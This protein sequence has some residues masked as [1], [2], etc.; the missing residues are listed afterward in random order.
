MPHRLQSTMPLGLF[1][2][3]IIDTYTE[4]SPLD[5]IMP[6]LY[7]AA[8]LAFGSQS[9]DK[10]NDFVFSILKTGLSK[11]AELYP[12]LTSEF[13]RDVSNHLILEQSI[14]PDEIA[15]V[16]KD[17]TQFGSEWIGSYQK[18][19]TSGMTGLDAKILAPIVAGIGTT[20]KLISAQVTFIPG[21][22]LLSMCFT[23]LLFDGQSAAL[24]IG[25]W[26]N[27]CR[28]LQQNPAVAKIR[29]ESVKPGENPVVALAKKLK[30]NYEELKGRPEL[31]EVLGLD[32]KKSGNLQA[33]AFFEMPLVIPAAAESP[34]SPGSSQLVSMI[35]SFSKSAL[36]SLKTTATTPAAEDSR[37]STH[38][39]LVAFL[40]RHILR[41]RLNSNDKIPQDKKSMLAVAVNGR[42]ELSIPESHIGNVIF[43]S[44]SSYS[45]RD[46][47]SGQASLAQ[48]AKTIRQNLNKNKK[49]FLEGVACASSIPNQAL[50]TLRYLIDDF[51]SQDILTT[52][53]VKM[54]YYSMEWGP[55]FSD[56]GGYIDFFRMPEGQF[57]GGNCIFPRKRNGDVEVVLNMKEEQMRRLISDKEF[58][59][60]ASLVA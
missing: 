46:V 34:L 36:E 51:V 4:F 48:L 53:W 40:W 22:M 56:N 44:I 41:A 7:Y 23:H 8:I 49:L 47:L 21:G 24:I 30:L 15:L 20:R 12:L 57:P 10:N 60:M 35:F 19:K 17:L 25:L 14:S 32:W 50:S 11:L 5:E 37:I 27:L 45:I 42:K 1:A 16:R 59:E 6:P 3:P 58:L 52:S 43:E 29:E 9:T 39:A 28:E 33:E 13:A 2:P 54:P 38:D 31:W 18:L 55:A 26:A